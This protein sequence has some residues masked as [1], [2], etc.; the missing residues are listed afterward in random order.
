MLVLREEAEERELSECE[1][2]DQGVITPLKGS[3]LVGGGPG[4][5]GS[6]GRGSV[7]GSVEYKAEDWPVSGG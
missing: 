3:D 6:V 5:R 4:G 1:D 2:D 7:S